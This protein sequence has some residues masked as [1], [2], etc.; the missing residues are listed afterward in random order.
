MSGYNS[1]NYLRFMKTN[2][3]HLT[4]LYNKIAR[5]VVLCLGANDAA[6]MNM[7]YELLECVVD[8][9]EYYNNM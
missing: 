1:R 2:I 5:Y 6:I 3:Y 9:D 8:L 7:N 4:A